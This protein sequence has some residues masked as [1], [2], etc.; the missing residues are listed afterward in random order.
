MFKPIFCLNYNVCLNL[1]QKFD[2]FE[3]YVLLQDTVEM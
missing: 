1:K 3:L 2:I